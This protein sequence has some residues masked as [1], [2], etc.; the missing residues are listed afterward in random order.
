LVLKVAGI[1]CIP[2]ECDSLIGQQDA[3]LRQVQKSISNCSPC[4]TFPHSKVR[5][6]MQYQ[7]E[8]LC[9]VKFHVLASI[10]V[11]LDC[12]ANE[13]TAVLTLLSSVDFWIHTSAVFVSSNSYSVPARYK[14]KELHQMIGI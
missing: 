13:F 1:C 14:K 3:H 6:R 12:L 2:F 7:D 10:K 9:E 5:S 4:A 8:S 11:Y